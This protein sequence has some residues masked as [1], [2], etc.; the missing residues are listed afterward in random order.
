MKRKMIALAVGGMVALGGA[1]LAVAQ[2]AQ[3]APGPGGPGARGPGGPGGR[4]AMM[5]ERMCQ[6]GPARLAAGLAFAEVRLAIT[7]AQ[8]PAWTTF[9]QEARASWAPI[10]RLCAEPRPTID[11]TDFAA[12]LGQRER[13]ATA[14]AESLRTLRPAVERIQAQLTPEQRR[15]AADLM[16]RGGGFGGRGMHHGMRG[17]HG[18][19]GP[20]GPGGPGAP[21]GPPRQ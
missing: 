5:M 20:M 2:Q 11:P 19:R 7:D 1:A 17:E 6:N 12:Q 15:V 13:W 3:T 8:R 21:G 10:A 14:F 18:P 16:R 9:T 4:G